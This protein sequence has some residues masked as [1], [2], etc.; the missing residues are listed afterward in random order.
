MLGIPGVLLFG[1]VGWR[2]VKRGGLAKFVG[3]LLGTWVAV[4]ALLWLAYFM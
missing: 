3:Y 1:Y 4:S 2:L